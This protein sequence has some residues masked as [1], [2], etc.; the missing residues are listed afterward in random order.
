MMKFQLRCISLIKMT[1]KPTTDMES[2]LHNLV[3]VFDRK[4]EKGHYSRF[5][6]DL[7]IGFVK[8]LGKNVGLAK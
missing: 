8:H 4:T 1:D 5:S 7:V 2:K 3:S 6:N